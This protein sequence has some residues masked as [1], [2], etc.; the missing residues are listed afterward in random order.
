MAW[1]RAGQRWGIRREVE[2]RPPSIRRPHHYSRT[3]QHPHPHPHT[4]LPQVL[5]RHLLAVAPARRVPPRLE[6]LRRGCRGGRGG[7]VRV[8]VQRQQHARAQSHAAAAASPAPAAPSLCPGRPPSCS[9]PEPRPSS[10]LPPAAFRVEVVHR[11][12]GERLAHA[13]GDES[14][15]ASSNQA[16]SWAIGLCRCITCLGSHYHRARPGRGQP[17]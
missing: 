9:P 11:V 13:G 4:H 3:R 1:Q 17:R 12:V 6:H 10:C 2:C 16:N 5:R 14:G 7:C 15:G 8:R